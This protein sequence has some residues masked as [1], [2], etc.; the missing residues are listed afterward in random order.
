M[1]RPHYIYLFAL[2]LLASLVIAACS[3]DAPVSTPQTPLTVPQTPLIQGQTVQGQ[4]AQFTP[5]PVPA[6]GGAG[7]IS[8][9]SASSDCQVGQIVG[10]EDSCTYPGT[11]EE[12]RVD[13]SGIA[14]FLLFTA[15][16][17]I[18]AR[19]ALINNEEYDFSARKQDDGNW[20][21]EVVGAPSDS[22]RVSDLVAAVSDTPTAT[23]TPVPPSQPAAAPSPVSTTAIIA[24]SPVPTP[25][26][27]TP[28]PVPTSVSRA[29]PTPASTQQ[30]ITPTST[31]EATPTPA[32]TPTAIAAA[33]ISPPTP[34]LGSTP[35]IVTDIVDRTIAVRSSMVMD[36]SQAF[37]E[38]EREEL[39]QFSV[40]TSDNTVAHARVNSITGELTLTG[41]R[42]GSSWVVLS[43][44]DANRCTELGD[45]TFLLT[46]APPASLPPQAVAP[47][48]AQQV[49]L[50][51]TIVVPLL[52]AF[53][54]VD[55]DRI[56]DFD[57]QIDDRGVVEASVDS[58]AGKMNFL[59][60]QV[61]STTVSVRACD[62]EACGD[63]ISALRFTVNVLPP[64][65]QPPIILGSISDQAVPVGEIITLD[66][67]NLFDDP[68]GDRIQDYGVSVTDGG[69]AVGSMDS[70]TGV[71]TLRGAKVGSTFVAVDASDGDP[72]TVKPSITF[73]V[74]VTEPVR[75]PPSVISSVSDQTIRLGR[76]VEFS[77]AP[78]FDAP[79]R[80]RIIRYDLLL[81]DPEVATDSEITRGG[82][83]TLKGSEKGRSWVSVRACNY[84]GCSDFLDLSFIL[85]VT[86]PDEEPDN[87]P[88]V[89]GGISDRILALGESET[90]DLSLAFEELDDSDHILDFEYEFSSPIVAKGSSISN[91]GTLILY[92]AS[93][94]ETTVSVSACDE[95][96]NCSDPE[97][98]SFK[99]T[100][101]APKVAQR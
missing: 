45:V 60:S 59:G 37:P 35:R 91:T 9:T 8:A 4:A 97:D 72:E 76:S 54:D 73:R 5:T 31:P 36:V 79:E 12:F 51:E 20:I 2:A 33:Q 88:A 50:G 78:A 90:L 23:A 93:I 34:D 52:P 95:Q 3:D 44:C 75:N 64:S 89:V 28:S 14:R 21:I 56:V 32:A 63:E 15:K 99:L 25:S 16:T 42:E 39:G 22:V 55:G 85:I 49:R 80:Y 65:N 92:G 18:Q 82:V 57:F 29:V 94:G 83:L 84:L 6:Q 81:K 19:N 69:V 71:L 74:T 101:T 46:V 66:A 30:P 40:I 87:A 13:E 7:D 11:S 96:N 70:R 48:P 10:N 41:L 61:G 98:F 38:L 24:E 1:A 58:S 86:D 68:E 67:S 47:I 17:V 62:V 53:R 77:V 27:L 100:V 26:A 43:A